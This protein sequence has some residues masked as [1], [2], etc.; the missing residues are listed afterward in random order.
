MSYPGRHLHG[1]VG[2]GDAARFWDA[3]DGWDAERKRRGPDGFIRC[4]ASG[5]DW[6]I[7]AEASRSKSRAARG[8][9]GGGA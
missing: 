5:S 2:F 7:P 9:G 3:Q 4:S 1:Y 8:E 6:S